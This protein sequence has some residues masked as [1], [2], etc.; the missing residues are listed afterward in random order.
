MCAACTCKVSLFAF[1]PDVAR[2]VLDRCLTDNATV[3][4]P[5]IM[6]SKEYKVTV[7]F[8]FLEDWRP[9]LP[10]DWGRLRDIQNRR[11][12]YLIQNARVLSQPSELLFTTDEKRTS[13]HTEENC[14]LWKPE[15]FSKVN[16]PLSLMV[17]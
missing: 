12:W 1:S 3:E 16:H 9:K 4:N 7:D 6:H 10:R 11:H 5:S 8:E 17:S 14:S 2:V 15:G 13:E